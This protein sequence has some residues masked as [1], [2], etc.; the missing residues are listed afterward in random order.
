MTPPDIVGLD[1]LKTFIIRTDGQEYPLRIN[2]IPQDIDDPLVVSAWMLEKACVQ[3]ADAY[4]REI[5]KDLDESAPMA[6]LS[7]SPTGLIQR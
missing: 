7:A 5:G 2:M 1:D 3:Q 6:A 4:L